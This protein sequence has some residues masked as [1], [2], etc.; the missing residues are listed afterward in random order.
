[1]TTIRG[2]GKMILNAS[3]DRIEP[4]KDYTIDNVQLVCSH[5]NMMKSNL[6]EDELYEFCKA[7]VNNHKD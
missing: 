7:I 5:V 6:S 2:S 4:G 3:I 1:M